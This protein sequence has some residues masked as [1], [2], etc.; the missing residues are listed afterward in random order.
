MFGQWGSPFP[1]SS[2]LYYGMF[3]LVFLPLTP[4]RDGPAVW[5]L[6]NSW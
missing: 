4:V 3:Q 1:S 6:V 5:P 2:E